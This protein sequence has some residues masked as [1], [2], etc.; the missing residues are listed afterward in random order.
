V[1]KTVNIFLITYICFLLWLSQDNLY[2]LLHSERLQSTNGIK[3]K[4]KHHNLC[5][6]EFI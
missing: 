2:V 3:P 1:D 6:M 5:N 4:I